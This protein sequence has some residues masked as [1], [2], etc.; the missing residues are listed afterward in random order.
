MSEIT[1]ASSELGS[2]PVVV[3]VDA[4]FEPLV[5]KF[6]TNRKKEITTMTEAVAQGDFETVR[7]VAHGMKGV[8]GSYGF[9]EMTAVAARLEQAAKAA[10]EGSIRNDL[11]ALASYLDR[12]EI[13]YE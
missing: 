3:H 1:R 6:M 10:E 7:K 8:S 12:V 11:T 2:G 5:P 13:V 4:S 9:P